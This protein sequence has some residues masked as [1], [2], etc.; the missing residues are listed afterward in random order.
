[1]NALV[2]SRHA[3][4]RMRQRGMRPHDLELLWRY[5]SAIGDDDYEVYFLKHKDAQR[6]IDR[7]NGEIRHR[8][9]SQGLP[10][11]MDRERETHRLK[12]VGTVMMSE[13]TRGRVDL[14]GLFQM[15]LAVGRALGVALFMIYLFGGLLAGLTML[16]VG[17]FVDL[18][19]EWTMPLIVGW[20]G[21]AVVGLFLYL[22]WR[23]GNL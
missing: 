13:P 23:S 4:T 2:L 9:R 5:G 11:R 20:A 8:T 21:V 16:I 12:N 17:L 15:L 14:D 3:E 19:D 1:M 10:A 22:D 7:L 18:G 6:E